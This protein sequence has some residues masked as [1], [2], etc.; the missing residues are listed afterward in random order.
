MEKLLPKAQRRLTSA[1]PWI[2]P[3]SREFGRSGRRPRSFI[4]PG[5]FNTWAD[6]A[7][8]GGP[9]EDLPRSEFLRNRGPARHACLAGRLGGLGGLAGRGRL[10]PRL[11]CL[12]D[13]GEELLPGRRCPG[14]LRCG[15]LCR[16]GRDCK[17]WGSRCFPTVFKGCLQVFRRC[18]YV[19]FKDCFTIAIPNNSCV[20][21][22]VSFWFGGRRIV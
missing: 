22:Y 7:S 12:G 4:S 18:F 20:T 5:T 15:A 19:M 3:V 14:R 13:L 6:L 11:R 10:P 1:A 9:R 2:V 21:I 8:L 16:P 17:W